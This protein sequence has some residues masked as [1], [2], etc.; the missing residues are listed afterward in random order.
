MK[1]TLLTRTITMAAVIATALL[2]ATNSLAADH[3][4]VIYTMNPT[5]THPGTNPTTGL[6]SDGAGNLYATDA[7]NIISGGGAVYQLV[8]SGRSYLYHEIV[9]FNF[10]D[11]STPVG[12]LAIDA[13][14]NLYGATEVGGAN[15]RYGNIFEISPIDGGK[16]WTMTILYTFTSS[17][18]DATGLTMDSKGNLFS[19]TFYGGTNKL[20]TVFELSPSGNGQWTYNTIHNFTAAEGGGPNTQLVFDTNGNLFGGQYA[21]DGTYSGLYELSPSSDG[22]WTETNV[23]TFDGATDGAQPSGPLVFD[24][25]GDMYGSNMVGGL[26][27]AGTAF[28]LTPDGSGGWNYL[29]IH[30]FG[31]SYLTD[32]YYPQGGLIRDSAGNLYGMNNQVGPSA[33]NV[34]EL[35]PGTD[36]QWTET[37][38]HSFRGGSDGEF[39]VSGLFMN[40]AGTLVGA[41]QA[42]GNG[43]GCG[44]LGCGVIFELVP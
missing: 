8:P 21:T 14:G 16:K 1:L 10:T 39:P 32:G 30:N 43:L 15:R 33:G 23:R 24:A 19:A 18:Y 31:Q 20:G 35:S 11:G 29:V 22:T 13:A 7:G 36:G 27:G 5:T 26:Y 3:Y 44:D 12:R 17:S 34:F 37:I 42:G 25:A 6:V 41:T 28:E 2:F 40:S 38:L 9:L 4:Q